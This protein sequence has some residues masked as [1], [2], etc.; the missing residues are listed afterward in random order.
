LLK[1]VGKS[2]PTIC[3]FV[4]LL[5]RPDL[6]PET[7]KI[8]VTDEEGVVESS[9]HLVRRFV[10]QR[11][12]T[13]E[14]ALLAGSRA[15]GSGTAGSDYDVVLLFP[16]L[17]NGAWREMVLFEGRY[18][19]GFGHDLG[20]LGYFCRELDRPSGKPV[21]PSMVAEGISILSENS[22]LLRTAREIASKTLRLGPPILSAEE[23]RRR[24][25]TIT[26]FASKLR[27]DSDRGVC[28]A[29]GT[30]L[31]VELADF[32][33][34]TAGH[35]SASGKAIP[36]ALAAVSP[37]LAEQF[38]IAFCALFANRDVAPVQALVDVVLQPQGGRLR[39]G[40]RQA[41]PASWTDTSAGSAKP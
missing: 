37:N 26:D 22:A 3:G 40:Y 41:A 30:S 28:L 6:R 33:L 18:I 7:E 24:C 35:W 21:L 27:S 5:G 31:F 14:A 8:A 39:D 10:V 16:L 1:N 34:R 17:P 38:E 15:R 32:A 36:R 4:A 13:A 25:Y 20:T 19:E 9:V 2:Q 11:H 23:I 12:P 29:V